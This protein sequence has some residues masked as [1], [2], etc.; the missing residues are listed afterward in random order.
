MRRSNLLNKC[1]WMFLL[2]ASLTLA[3]AADPQYDKWMEVQTN[4]QSWTGDFTQ[5]RSLKVLAQPLVSA[6]KVWVTPDKFRWDLGQPPQSTVLRLPDELLILY[7]QLKRAEKYPLAGIPP[8]PI[9]DAL[10]LLD[11]SFP[12]DRATMEARFKLV[13]AVPTN[14]IFEVTLEPRSS[15]ARK[16][17]S[18]VII[19]FHTNDFS[20]ASTEMKF[21]D[22]S[23]L[24]NEFS[25]VKMNVPIDPSLFDSKLP[26][27]YTVTQPLNQ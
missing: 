5:T 16:I 3:A 18:N 6:G 9:K 2:L 19:G 10:G 1:L 27:D 12:R 20:M 26:P 22:G 15:S 4:L 11:A 25:N 13:S 21:G 14:S 23:S 24:R 17:I 7:P 8:G